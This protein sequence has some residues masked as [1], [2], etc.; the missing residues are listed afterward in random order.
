MQAKH[1]LCPILPLQLTTQKPKNPNYPKQIL[2]VGDEF[3]TARLDKELTQ[4]IVAKILNVN[5]NFVG[6]LELNQKTLSI[7]ALHKAYSFLGHIHKTLNFDLNTLQGKLFA[8]GIKNNVT[9]SK[10]AKQ[11]GLDKGTLIRVERSVS[12]KEETKIKIEK[13][14]S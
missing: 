13:F 1:V 11:I 4:H 14:L 3:R 8:Y 12:V 10:L 7:F 2:T 5:K 9:Y 6:E